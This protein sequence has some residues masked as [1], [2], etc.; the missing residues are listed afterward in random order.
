MKKRWIS[1]LCAALLVFLPGCAATPAISGTYRTASSDSSLQT[2]GVNDTMDKD[3]GVA[4]NDISVLSEESLMLLRDAGITFVK[5][6]V[7]YPFEADG[8]TLNANY[9]ALK[10]AMKMIHEAGLKVLAQSFTPGGTRYDATAGAVGWVSN[11]PNVFDGYEDPYFYK[12]TETGTAY[13]AED[14]KEYTNW[15]LVSN[16]PDV[17]V[18]TGPMTS[19]QI[20]DYLKAGARGLKKGNPQAKTGVNMMV[21]INPLYSLQL[22]SRIFDDQELFDFMGLDSYFGTLMAGSPESWNA[23]I[24]QFYQATGKPIVITEWAYSSAVYDPSRAPASTGLSYNSPVC[25]DKAFSFEWE[26]HARSRE[27]QAAYVEACLSI[28]Q[29]NPHIIGSFWFCI[30]DYDG[31][32]WECGDL[33]CP[34]NSEW[35]LLT[36]DNQPKPA[37]EAFRKYTEAE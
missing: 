5:L 9:L 22:T 17:N 30:N 12:I 8:V 36:A 31:P 26:G 11:L 33:F 24:E 34:M 29:N 10:R 19:E 4:C 18:F 7:P 25:R 37:Y 28:F 23:Y 20:G 13:I 35:G 15:W 1:G 27:T 2:G 32:C 6:H 14:L 3:I 16:E 21:S